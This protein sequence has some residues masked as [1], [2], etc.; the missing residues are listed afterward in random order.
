MLI[1]VGMVASVEGATYTFGN[2]TVDVATTS[3]GYIAN[4]ISSPNL[5]P[6]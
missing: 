2:M 3:S 1:V 4:G 5:L 6:P